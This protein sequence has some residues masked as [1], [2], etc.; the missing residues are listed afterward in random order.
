MQRQESGC[1]GLGAQDLQQSGSW[2]AGRDLHLPGIGAVS[3]RS[4][5]AAPCAPPACA[6][7]HTGSSPPRDASPTRGPHAPRAGVAAGGSGLG[8]GQGILA[9]SSARVLS[10]PPAALSP[11][12]AGCPSPKP[13]PPRPIGVVRVALGK[14]RSQSGPTYACRWVPGFLPGCLAPRSTQPCCN[15]ES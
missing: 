15:A 2:A 5:A 6:P 1:L 12:A 7:T 11:T 14:A 4:L 3:Q 9:S 13:A 8:L 10:P